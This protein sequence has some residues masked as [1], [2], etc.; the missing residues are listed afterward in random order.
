MSINALASLG[1]ICKSCES[2][3]AVCPYVTPKLIVLA[4]RRSSGVIDLSR[5]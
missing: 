4:M 2:P 5:R 3:Y 1:L